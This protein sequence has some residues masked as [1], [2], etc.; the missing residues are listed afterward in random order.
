MRH[1]ERNRRADARVRGVA[2]EA[3]EHVQGLRLV[4]PV[5]KLRVE[6]DAGRSRAGRCAATARPAAPSA[7]TAAKA[8]A[9]AAAPALHDS[10]RQVLRHPQAQGLRRR[11]G[12]RRRVEIV[13]RAGEVRRRDVGQQRRGARID[14]RGRNLVAR[15]RLAGRRVDQLNRTRREV[16]VP[17]RIGRDGGVLIEEVRRAIAREVQLEIRPPVRVG[18]ESRYLERSAERCAEG[19][20]RVRRLGRRHVAQLGTEPR[21]ARSRR[22]YTSPIPDTDSALARRA[23]RARSRLAR[24]H[25]LALQSRRDRRVLLPR[26]RGR[27]AAPRARHPAARWPD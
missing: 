24:V 25:H 14:S 8:A 5:L 7:E 27:P 2:A 10:R 23:L 13:R 9:A 6:D 12:R 4:A 11:P 18:V 22:T 15:K 3:R 21:S 16:A 1:V 20:L 26:G 17:H 19:V